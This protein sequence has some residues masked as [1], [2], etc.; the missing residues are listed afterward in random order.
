M[1][2]EA[3]LSISQEVRLFK[4][5][6]NCTKGIMPVRCLLSIVQLLFY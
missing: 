4:R 3:G 5:I 1:Q 6:V 2:K